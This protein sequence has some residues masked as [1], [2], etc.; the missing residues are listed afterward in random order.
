[1]ASS[2]HADR[3]RERFRGVAVRRREGTIPTA[4]RYVPVATLLTASDGSLKNN[5]SSIKDNQTIK[6]ASVGPTVEFERRHGT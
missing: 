6:D 3:L 1:M 4:R 5:Q 2:M